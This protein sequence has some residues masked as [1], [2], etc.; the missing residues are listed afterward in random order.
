MH[1]HR[2]GDWFPLPQ[3]SLS[4]RSPLVWKVIV[5]YLDTLLGLHYSTCY[6][7]PQILHVRIWKPIKCQQL[8]TLIS[9]CDFTTH[10]H[11]ASNKRYACMP[12]P[13]FAQHHCDSLQRHGTSTT[14]WKLAAIIKPMF[15][16]TVLDCFHKFLPIITSSRHC[17]D[18]KRQITICEDRRQ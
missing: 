15:S 12:G 7:K 16:F 10:L 1:T 6:F 4:E 14:L 8:F 18:L 13:Q 17:K 9:A 2:S 3:R 5:V 11:K